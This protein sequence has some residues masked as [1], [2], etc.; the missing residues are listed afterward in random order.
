MK[1]KSSLTSLNQRESKAN[2]HKSRVLYTLLL[3]NPSKKMNNTSTMH[4]NTFRSKF[5]TG[6]SNHPESK[7]RNE[8]R[9][10]EKR[11]KQNSSE[12]RSKTAIAHLRRSDQ[13][14]R[15]REVRNLVEWRGRVKRDEKTLITSSFV[16]RKKKKRL[17]VGTFG[18]CEREK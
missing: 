12:I 8:R 17:G 11:K 15:R 6:K 4:R 16:R 7:A 2:L 13:I 1:Q 9:K 3:L 10:K 18:C 14:R 5:P